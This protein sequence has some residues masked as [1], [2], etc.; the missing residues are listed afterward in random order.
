MALFDDLI[1]RWR[2]SYNWNDD[3]GNG[4]TLVPTSN[5]IDGVGHGGTA[6]AA[7]N[8]STL[9]SRAEVTSTLLNSISDDFSIS[10]WFNYPNTGYPDELIL[11]VFDNIDV[12]PS[13]GVGVDNSGNLYYKVTRSGTATVTVPSSTA[14]D[15]DTWYHIVVTQDAT[16]NE[17]KIYTNGVNTGTGDALGLPKAVPTRPF[18]IGDMSFNNSFVG[19]VDDVAIFSK[20]LTIDDV[21]ELYALEDDFRESGLFGNSLG[22]WKLNTS[23][24]DD[25]GNGL[26]LTDVNGTGTT[27]GHTSVLDNSARTFDGV[28]QLL[29]NG[30]SLLRDLGANA[31][32][33]I[34]IW[35]KLDQKTTTQYFASAWGSDVTDQSYVVAYN[36]SGQFQIV[37]RLVDETVINVFSNITVATGKWYYLTAVIVNSSSATLYVDGVL[38]STVAFTANVRSGVSESFVLGGALFRADRQVTGAIDDVIIYDRALTQNDIDAIFALGDDFA[39]LTIFDGAV[40][41]W[42]LNTTLADD[43][44]NNITL[45]DVNGTGTTLGHAEVLSDS[46]RTFN[47]T[48]QGLEVTNDLLNKPVDI[49]V[50][51]WIYLTSSP[52]DDKRI[53]SVW[54]PTP[55]DRAFSLYVTPSDNIYAFIYNSSGGATLAISTTTVT[56]NT[57]YHV[58]F[59]FNSKTDFI[60]LYVNAILEG[61][62]QHSGGVNTT[63]GLF[64]IGFDALSNAD[65]FPGYIDD[66]IVYRRVVSDTEVSELYALSD[67][68]N[69]S[70]TKNIIGQWKL[71]A[72]LQDISGN[73]L[74]LT[75]VGG[76]GTATG[77]DG[78][79]DTARTFNGTDQGLTVTNNLLTTMQ[80]AFSISVWIYPTR[81][82]R[83]T[84]E[85][86]AGSWFPDTNKRAYLLAINTSN[87]LTFLVTDDGTLNNAWNVNSSAEIPTNQWSHLVG[88]FNGV[89][90]LCYVNGV[91]NDTQ[92][93]PYTQ[94]FQNTGEP[95]DVGVRSVDTTGVF[96]G[97]IDDLIVYDR[98]LTQ[99]DIDALY[100]LGDDFGLPLQSNIDITINGT[101][102]GRLEV[103]SVEY[104]N[105]SVAVTDANVLNSPIWKPIQNFD[106]PAEVTPFTPKPDETIYIVGTYV[107]TIVP[108]TE[109]VI[110]TPR[111]I[112]RYIDV[113]FE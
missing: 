1:A 110:D 28:D 97:Y 85:R 99:D 25:S 61:T 17:V 89:S 72:S 38:Q 21:A 113:E 16:T 57:W 35:V 106:S 105:A 46:A 70:Y 91:L 56:T 51:A 15:I 13:W 24:D 73:D 54:G 41:K 86:I 33:S 88:V 50:S 65:Y 34:S 20:K 96:E 100:A 6:N 4:L 36:A 102:D 104:P 78:N 92:S 58:C 67:D 12:V 10:F 94:I 29:T 18:N 66:V 87:F 74:T 107:T 69:P 42:K 8:F 112:K 59:T 83:T 22:K 30:S 103:D 9:S 55:A 60:E 84:T 32:F 77:H 82:T 31:A 80:G 47:G 98:N 109:E 101:D 2:L 45:T 49:S 75:D 11:G 53:A 27:L 52:E 68:F 3:S 64:C 14:I 108:V 62:G 76:T 79:A 37:L 43:T 40:G 48:N 39:T 95:F 93:V 71:N 90:L 63:D 23:L 26:T 111:A 81:T 5:P 7:K 44:T 19:V